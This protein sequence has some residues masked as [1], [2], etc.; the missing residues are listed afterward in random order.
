MSITWVDTLPENELTSDTSIQTLSPDWAAFSKT[1]K[2]KGT[3][4]IITSLSAPLACPTTYRF[5]ASAVNNVYTNSGVDPN[6]RGQTTR[7]VSFVVGIKHGLVGS[8]SETGEQII[9]PLSSHI[10]VKVPA[11]VEVNGDIILGSIERL[12][13]G[14]DDTSI[15]GATRRERVAKRINSI[16]RGGLTPPTLI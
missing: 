12:L 6:F 1:D 3:D 7:G 11:N 16:L 15:L 13:G 14:L 8:D 9:L 10:V 2:S 5:Q 4:V